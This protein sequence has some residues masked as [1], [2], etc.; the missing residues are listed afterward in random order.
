MDDLFV[1]ILFLHSNIYPRKSNK[2][3]TKYNNAPERVK[4]VGLMITAGWQK[5][6]LDQY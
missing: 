4:D 2:T 3:Q 5:L 6:Y 1:Q